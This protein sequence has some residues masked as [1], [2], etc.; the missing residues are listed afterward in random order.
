MVVRIVAASRLKK[1]GVP[2]PYWLLEPSAL[3]NPGDPRLSPA[4]ARVDE[5]REAGQ[6]R[7]MLKRVFAR[8]QATLQRLRDRVRRWTR[9]ESRPLVG[10]A[11][12][13]LR[14]PAALRW[15]NA[16]LRKQLEQWRERALTTPFA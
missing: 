5:G 6:S 4:L 9:P 3:E 8:L 16:L 15:E 10:L 7:N 1:G 13:H 12:D 14:S 11:L 2:A